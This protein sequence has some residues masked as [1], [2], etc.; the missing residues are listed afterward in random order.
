M[1][2]K[3]LIRPYYTWYDTHWFSITMKLWEP[4]ASHRKRCSFS[5]LQAACPLYH[6]HA[7]SL[8]ISS[9][10]VH[11]AHAALN[12]SLSLFKYLEVTLPALRNASNARSR[13]SAERS[14]Q[15]EC[16]T[17]I[18]L[19][20][21]SHKDVPTVKANGQGLVPSTYNIQSLRMQQGSCGVF[22][23]DKIHSAFM[24]LSTLSLQA[25]PSLSAATSFRSIAAQVPAHTGLPS[26]MIEG[27]LN[28]MRIRI[29]YSW[30]AISDATNWC[31]ARKSKLIQTD[32]FSG[33]VVIQCHLHF[34][35]SN[36]PSSRVIFKITCLPWMVF[37]CAARP[38]GLRSAKC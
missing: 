28:K 17:W 25:L 23:S 30:E 5:N 24:Q 29:S 6:D 15:A 3:S 21:L 27:N 1:L 4:A 31:R 22:S 14:S 13:S 9:Y 18:G 8:H 26:S 16:W 2:K 33:C 37:G 38:E 7:E 36:K 19:Q 34:N 35:D 11:V 10:P 20:F 32:T 12:L